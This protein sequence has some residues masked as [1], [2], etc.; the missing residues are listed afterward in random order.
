MSSDSTKADGHALRAYRWVSGLQEIGVLIALVLLCVALA[1]STHSTHTFLD[2]TNLLQVARQASYYGIMAVGM[3]F[4]V[5]M[6]D[7]DLSVGSILTLTNVV[8]AIAL[9]SNLPVPLALLIGVATGAACGFVNGGLAVLLRIP[10]IIVTL[11][12]L[13]VYH[14]LALMFC[15]ATPVHEFSKESFLFTVGGN[16]ILGIP[17]SVVMMLIVG[18]V[19]WV[20]ITRTSH[21]RHVVAIGGNPISARLSG[22]PINKYRIAVMTLNGVIAA[23]AGIMSLAFLQSA[24]PSNGVG[25]ELWVIA[26]VIIGGTALSGG[27]GSVPGAILGALI[28]AVIRNGLILIGAPTY[29]GTAV[30][31]AV[32]IIAVAI[33]SLVKRRTQ[34]KH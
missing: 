28:I 26:S 8:T 33:D 6:G 10:M 31:G 16:E 29:A 1:I 15:S 24:D 12:T 11:G 18:A 5:S 7:I 32:I 13:S 21:G 17:S 19:G 30:T 22:L 3:V 25:S 23:I 9:R 27:K 14:G 34:P 2:Q 20:S 4:V